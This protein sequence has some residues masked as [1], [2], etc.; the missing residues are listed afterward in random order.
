TAAKLGDLTLE[1]FSR[2]MAKGGKAIFIIAE[3]EHSLEVK[4]VSADQVTLTISSTPM[5]VTVDKGET[6]SVDVSNDG[7][8]DIEITFHGVDSKKRADITFKGIPQPGEEGAQPVEKEEPEQA[9]AEGAGSATLIIILVIV[10]VVIIGYFI[11]R[12]KQ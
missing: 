9:P 4:E 6:T 11:V 12:R 3:E 10:V 5:D 1:G 8:N 7:Y 2:L